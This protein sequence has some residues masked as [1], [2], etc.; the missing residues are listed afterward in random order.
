MRTLTTKLLAGFVALTT[1]L[2]TAAP[3]LADQTTQQDEKYLTLTLIGDSYTAGNGIGLYYG[4]EESYRSMRNWG[5]IYAN[6]LNENGVHTT[7][8]N[9]A[10]SGQIT[11]GVLTNQI[12]KVPVDT[13]IVL[14]T[15]GG[16]DIEFQNIIT[17]C[18]AGVLSSASKCKTAMNV[19]ESKIDETFA[20]VEHILE[21][22]AE[23]LAPDAQI[24]M[25]GYPY[26]S[27]D[28]SFAWGSFDAA[29]EVRK[30]GLK[31]VEL[32]TELT[33]KWNTDPTHPQ[34][35]FVPT[36]T[37][38]AGHEPDPYFWGTN[39]QRWFNELAE[40]NGYIDE[41][42]KL[43]SEWSGTTLMFYH[44]NI[45]GH[46]E[47]GKLVY[48]VV[49][50]PDSARTKPS[51]ARPIDVTF[52]V[53][54]SPKT[55][56]KIGEIKKQIKRIAQET[57]DASTNANQDARFSLRSYIRPELAQDTPA[58]LAEE[59]N[60]TPVENN[61]DSESAPDIVPDVTVPDLPDT[62]V[63]DLPDATV[64]DL[65]SDTPEDTEPTPPAG[66]AAHSDFGP[67][68]HVL[69][70]LDD[71][72]T[73]TEENATDLFTTLTQVTQSSP[74]RAQAR[75]IVV[76]IGDA[77]TDQN[78]E[79]VSQ[80]VEQLL[81]SAFAANTVEFNLIDL[82]TERA[83]P[84]TMLFTRT[85]GRIQLLGDLR[86]L[87]LEAPTAKLGQVPTQKIGNAIE[88]S[89]DGSLSPNSDIVRYEWH[90][91]NDPAATQTTTEPTTSFAFGSAGE[92]QV[93]VT[94]TDAD[95]QSATTTITVTVTEDGDL[96]AQDVDNC[97]D[98]A[99]EDQLDTDGDGIG[100]ACD[101]INQ[102]ELA[103]EVT[104]DGKTQSFD[105]HTL[106]P[107]ATDITL[108]YD[109][110][111]AKGWTIALD[112]S[113]LSYAASEAVANRSQIT[114]TIDMQLPA[115]ATVLRQVPPMKSMSIQLQLTA[116]NAPTDLI[117]LTPAVEVIPALK[118]APA[119][120]TIP[121][122]PLGPAA[123]TPQEPV[124]KTTAS[125]QQLA[126]TGIDATAL[127]AFALL[128]LG[129]GIAFNRRAREEA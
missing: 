115:P 49:G 107:G 59:E 80:S 83:K 57:H 128:L 96:I 65:P 78:T 91:G 113:V 4:P 54:S 9:L 69:S 114:V 35:T 31:A 126:H 79:S 82:D 71:L 20:N 72:N 92:Y 76:V 117:P 116:K 14:F 23:R 118:L 7:V 121:A 11:D 90:F 16:N 119:T 60:L 66:P 32:Q 127:G 40:T 109:Q 1:F 108:S 29:R 42:G 55:Q 37:A 75:K 120:T 95:Q 10:E 89:A 86:P 30:F 45:T 84:L 61:G 41:N 33:K 2:F 17:G 58:D 21:K 93:S 38:F 94:V 51:F 64:P 28:T 81:L 52:L 125:E 56:E 27:T 34:V 68:A 63:T 3:A 62:T 44:P 111:S 112:E 39:P 70:A 110:E 100:D 5:H 105:V 26:L 97:P 13:D 104:I 25:V 36:H 18:F 47:I 6:K 123:Q 12:P 19:A 102:I 67:L 46:E 87:I 24:V 22:L 98:V 85:G 8:H 124:V 74:W 50:V 99:N 77:E 73:T 88:F 129:P 15:I 103:K 53:E 43:V 106:F 101:P 122:L 48:N